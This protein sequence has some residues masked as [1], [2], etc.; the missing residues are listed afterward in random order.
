MHYFLLM[1]F[2]SK[3]LH[4]SSRLAALHQ[5]DQLCINSNWYSHALCWL[6]ALQHNAWLPIAVCTELILLMN[7]IRIIRH[8]LSVRRFWFITLE[9]LVQTVWLHSF[10]IIRKYSVKSQIFI[11]FWKYQRKHSA[12]SISFALFP[13][14]FFQS[15]FLASSLFNCF[16]FLLF[17]CCRIGR[18]YN[19]KFRTS[20]IKLWVPTASKKKTQL[21]LLYSCLW[22]IPRRLNFTWQHKI[23]TP[24]NRPQATIQHPQHNEI[25]KSGTFYS[26]LR[27]F[28]VMYS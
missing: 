14:R 15:V 11:S 10:N 16:S 20:F 3:A 18:F 6:A 12:K 26:V 25:L 7:V 23:Q 24:G 5:E 22:V 28:V 19:V 1:Y 8:I 9:W 17:F 27:S 4:I 2:N 21:I 13:F